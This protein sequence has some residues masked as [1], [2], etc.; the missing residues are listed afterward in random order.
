MWTSIF[1][2]LCSFNYVLKKVSWGWKKGSQVSKNYSSC[3]KLTS[4]ATAYIS[5]KT[6]CLVTRYLMPFLTS[7]GSC[8][9]SDS[10][11]T[12]TQTYTLTPSMYNLLLRYCTYK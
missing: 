4:L 2:E 8:N 5:S 12:Y 6:V 9:Q 1:H 11:L 7:V 10:I 3:R